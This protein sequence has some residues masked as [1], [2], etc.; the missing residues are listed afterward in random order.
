MNHDSHSLN[1]WLQHCRLPRLE[2]RLLLAH[3]AGISH[4]HLIAHGDDLLPP[5]CLTQ[6]N[7]AVSR[8]QAGE[9]L[10]YII[11][12]REFYGRIFSVSDAVLIPR[13][14]TEHLVEAALA[15]LPPAGTVW[16]L[17]TGSG[18]IA[19]TLA[20][21]RPGATV[22]AADISQPAL[23]IARHNA[24]KMGVSIHWGQGSWFE[25]QPQPAI[26]SVDV[27][28]SNPPYIEQHDAHL[29]QGDLRFEPLS[30][31]TDFADGLQAL[32]HIIQTAP[33]W[34]KP[35]GW[36]VLEHGFDQ[37]SRVRTLLE[38]QHFTQVHTLTDLAGLDR[39]SLGQW[40]PQ[41]G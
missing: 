14:E 37:G 25:A 2:A 9:P 35:G 40:I 31:L 15:H 29:N 5:A 23:H 26:G 13:P 11:Q 4:S 27:I 6:L 38:Q 28:V 33:Q 21:E 36:L 8:R 17:G 1:D 7:Q 16:D 22:W 10:A 19:V 30:A 20:C 41:A 34:L 12:E 39:V 32:Q 24:S 3:F 18:A